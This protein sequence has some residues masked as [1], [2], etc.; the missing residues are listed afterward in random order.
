MYPEVVQ[1]SKYYQCH[2]WTCVIRLVV[3]AWMFTEPSL[4]GAGAPKSVASRNMRC[5]ILGSSAKNKGKANH[6]KPHIAATVPAVNPLPFWGPGWHIP[7]T[8]RTLEEDLQVRHSWGWFKEAE[9]KQHL[10]FFICLFFTE[11]E[12]IRN[13]NTQQVA[14]S[15]FKNINLPVFTAI[16][17]LF[18]Y[19]YRSI[20]I[21]IYCIYSPLYMYTHKSKHTHTHGSCLMTEWLLGPGLGREEYSK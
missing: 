1:S 16:M 11:I 5:A 20:Y 6:A 14:N 2:K 15:L 4:I 19:I 9:Q 21:Y 3:H 10:Q 17:Y 7:V 13:M 8:S 18:G 12:I